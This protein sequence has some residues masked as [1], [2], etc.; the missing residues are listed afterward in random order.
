MRRFMATALLLVSGS[1]CAQLPPGL[2][3][4]NGFEPPPSLSYPSIQGAYQVEFEFLPLDPI[5][6]PMQPAIDAIGELFDDPGV[7][8]LR[9]MAIAIDGDVYYSE[10]TWSL[11][12]EI[13]VGPGDPLADCSR[14]GEIVPTA[15]GFNIAGIIEA[16]ADDGLK[17]ILGEDT[18]LVEVLGSS[19]GILE[20]VE[21]FALAGSLTISQETDENG[22]LGDRNVVLLNRIAWRWEGNERLIFLPLESGLASEV[23]AAVVFHPRDSETMSLAIDPFNLDLNYPK[24]LFTV[25]EK[26]LFPTVIDPEVDSLSDLFTYLVNCSNLADN[27]DNDGWGIVSPQLEIAC[28][29][30]SVYTTANSAIDVLIETSA[31]DLSAY[32]QLR[33]P[34][35]D[36]CPLVLDPEA[37]EATVKGF[38]GA[39]EA[40]RCEWDATLINVEPEISRTPMQ[41]FWWGSR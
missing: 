34:S 1:L 24:L 3:F 18:S 30:L 28:E 39:E 4:K 22:L 26:V 9:I 25:V 32:L 8:L 2:I 11:F 15:F 10:P 16:T 40:Q 12:F 17:A 33:T 31:P 23:G 36:P 41:A 21:N 13:C 38:G 14:A 7:F 29:A 27:L 6:T 19:L 35:F 37:A 5:P 20:N